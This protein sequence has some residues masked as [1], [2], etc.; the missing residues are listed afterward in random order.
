[1]LPEIFLIKWD[2]INKTWTILK[3]KKQTKILKS[4]HVKFKYNLAIKLNTINKYPLTW[5]GNYYISEKSQR[6]KPLKMIHMDLKHFILTQ[7]ISV[8]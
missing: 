5:I 8:H 6:R 4:H 1:M 3:T 7:Q 2:L